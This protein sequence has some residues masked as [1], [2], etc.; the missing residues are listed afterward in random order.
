MILFQDCVVKYEFETRNLAR[1]TDPHPVKPQAKA[2]LGP[3]TSEWSTRMLKTHLARF[4]TASVDPPSEF[5]SFNLPFIKYRSLTHYIYVAYFWNI[6][7]TKVAITIYT[8]SLSY[9]VFKNLNSRGAFNFVRYHIP[10]F[11]S[12]KILWF[13]IVSSCI[14]RRF[15][16]IS[17]CSEIVI[18]QSKRE[19]I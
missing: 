9:F 10:H 13:Q 8:S 5:P 17:L 12:K 11:W 3:T 14:C 6:A 19:D 2:G 4:S 18:Y 7:S 1:R 15:Y 16:E